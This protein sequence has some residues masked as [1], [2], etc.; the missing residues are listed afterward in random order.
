[1]STSCE[2][3]SY[4]AGTIYYTDKIVFTAGAGTLTCERLVFTDDTDLID[5]SAS[6]ID[7]PRQLNKQFVLIRDKV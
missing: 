4:S 7:Y 1:M 2:K 3:I 6:I 5:T